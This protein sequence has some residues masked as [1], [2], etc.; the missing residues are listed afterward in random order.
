M[1]AKELIY[2]EKSLHCMLLKSMFELTKHWCRV[3]K[4]NKNK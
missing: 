1:W 2:K 3:V 4:L